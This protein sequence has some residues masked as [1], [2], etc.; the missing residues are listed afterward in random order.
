MGP[1]PRIDG[2]APSWKS[3]M[4]PDGTPI[5]H[6]WKWPQ[7]GG[8]PEVRYNLEPIGPHAGTELDP[9]CQLAAKD[10]MG[11][12]ATA[13][14]SAP[15]DNTLFNHFTS[16]LFE[17]STNPAA[18]T[19]SGN[20]MHSTVFIAAEFLP[21]S[22]NFKTYIQPP[23]SA[24]EELMTGIELDS[25]ARP[26]V[27]DFLRNS[28]E[29]KL[30]TPFRLGVD[31]KA[32]SRLMWY[33]KSPNTTFAS[34]RNIMTLGGYI[35]TPHIERQLAELHSLVKAILGLPDG[36]SETECPAGFRSPYN[37]PPPSHT[38]DG[39]DTST[40]SPMLSGYSY[41][42]DVA[43][44][45]EFPGIK[46]SLPV[47]EYD[48]DDLSVAKALTA[49]MERQGRGAYSKRYL[50]LLMRLAAEKGLRL[51]ESRGLQESISILLKPDGGFDITTY[52]SSHA[53]DGQKEKQRVL[54]SF[55]KGRR[56][57]GGD[58]YF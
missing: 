14:P 3:Q 33:F 31:N 20:T 50:S 21:D 56:R 54:P 42:F 53:F 34:V 47:R 41:Y 5:K 51:D 58:L 32:G 25:P 55:R 6:S 13:I 24:H 49:W 9:L 36:F 26:M 16:M 22:I 11:R 8:K 44:G 35:K 23:T 7:A 28:D 40:P 39:I 2:A 4:Q 27:N 12:L 15:I 1:A 37:F 57:R 45:L 38:A 43:P 48:R 10:L 19:K 29:G 52:F 30:M 46:W 18:A 17:H